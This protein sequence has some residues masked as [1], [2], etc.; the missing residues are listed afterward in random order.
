MR[1][2]YF[3]LPDLTT[4]QT[5]VNELLLSHVEERHI[6]V[7]A[8][9][10]TPLGDLPE[11]TLMQKSDFVPALEKGL[12]IGGAAGALAGLVAVT[13]PPAGLV[14]GGGAVFGITLAGAGLGAWASTMIGAG[15]PNTQLKRFEED[16]DAGRILM[17]VDIPKT[18][19]G[20][21]EKLVRSHHPDVNIGGTEPIKPVFP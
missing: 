9:E 6:H 12:T 4:A 3:V 18:R 21:V 10:G 5:V 2:L 16:I 19:I 14:L 7:V 1:R 11:A 8:R 17:L 20:E 15:E 13:V